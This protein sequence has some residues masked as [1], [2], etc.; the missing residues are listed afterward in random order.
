LIEE[1]DEDDADEET[2]RRLCGSLDVMFSFSINIF[3]DFWIY[4]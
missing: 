4:K 3:L 2:E 1:G